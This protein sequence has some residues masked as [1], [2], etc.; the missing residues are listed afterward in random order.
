MVKYHDKVRHLRTDGR[1]VR[2]D[3]TRDWDRSYSD[4]FILREP[5]NK[6]AVGL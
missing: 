4:W 5:E 6:N 2:G 3:D 1:W